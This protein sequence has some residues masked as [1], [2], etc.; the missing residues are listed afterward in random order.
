MGCGHLR[1]R[2]QGEKTS[3]DIFASQSFQNFIAGTSDA[4]MP[5]YRECIQPRIPQLAVIGFSEGY[6]SIWTSEMRCRWVAELLDG[7][8]KLPSI[9]EMEKDVAEWDEKLKLYC[10]SYYRTKCI[11][12]LHI[13]TMINYAKIWDGTQGGRRDSLLNFLSLMALWTMLPLKPALT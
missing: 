8:F 1:N 9:K 7:T 10:G 2:I 11:G 4:A 5:I 13:G 6:S 12:A 3:S